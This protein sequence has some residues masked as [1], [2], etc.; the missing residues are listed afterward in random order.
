MQ[1]LAPVPAFGRPAGRQT[2]GR[3][4]DSGPPAFCR[5]PK[6]AW[7]LNACYL[8]LS[9]EPRK[10]RC[11]AALS[12]P[13]RGIRLGPTAHCWPLARVPQAYNQM[14]LASSR[15]RGSKQAR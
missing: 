14:V 7:K 4:S 13:R 6:Q 1:R 8:P 3:V 12:G 15:W 9:L 10:R 5:R 2:Y 11:G